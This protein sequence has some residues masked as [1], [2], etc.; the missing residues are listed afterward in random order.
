[1]SKV[2]EFSQVLANHLWNV[3]VSV[4]MRM[5]DSVP[6]KF[7]RNKCSIGENY[8]SSRVARQQLMAAIT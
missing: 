6:Q 3:C 8:G 7:S 4:H 5:P 1:M 2:D